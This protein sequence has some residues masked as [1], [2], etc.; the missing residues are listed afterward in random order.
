MTPMITAIYASLLGLM[1]VVLSFRIAQRR[2]R[3]Q[4]GVGTGQNKELE[5]AIRVH[6]NFSEYVPFALILLALFES[7]GGPA[8]SVHSAGGLLVLARLAHAFGLSRSAG[9][10]PGRFGGMVLTWA[11]IVALSVANLW[12]ALG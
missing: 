5:L 9:R 7:A 8:L 1:Y 2:M 10:S 4:V 12:A 6:G 3:F 11:I